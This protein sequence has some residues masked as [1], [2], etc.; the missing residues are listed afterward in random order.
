MSEI[1]ALV[2]GDTHGD[3]KRFSSRNFKY[4][5]A[6][7]LY[8]NGY[9]N[10]TPENTFVFICGDFGGV[11]SSKPFKD[12]VKNEKYWLDWLATKP[13]TFI[14]VGGNHENYSAIEANYQLDQWRGATVRF[15]RSNIIWVERGEIIELDGKRFWCFGGAKS[16]DK[17]WRV[18]EE[19][20]WAREQASQAEYDYGYKTF[21]ENWDNIDYIIS[22]AAPAQI[23]NFM[24]GCR[25]DSETE[26][27]LNRIWWLNQRQ[28]PHFCGHMHHNF[29]YDMYGYDV[30]I[31]YEQI[32]ELPESKIKVDKESV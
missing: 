32:M 11:F 17:D 8:V 22:H 3:F 27:F 12:E 4:K 30:T 24:P 7:G 9:D 26:I 15:I 6:N 29:H 23:A 25:G 20:W 13:V 1:K 16:T 14:I 19:S 31:L 10:C 18:P 21:S 28:V 2:C 5:N